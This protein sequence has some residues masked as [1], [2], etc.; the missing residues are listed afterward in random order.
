MPAITAGAD[1]TALILS[2]NVIVGRPEGAVSPEG[3]GITDC[4]TASRAGKKASQG[5]FVILSIGLVSWFWLSD[6][7]SGSECFGLENN[8]IG[9]NNSADL[10]T[11]YQ[12]SI[13]KHEACNNQ[14][15]NKLTPPYLFL[16]F[17]GHSYYVSL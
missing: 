2:L 5:S 13:L 14:M 7:S 4:D 16:F 10:V 1:N 8:D 17:V 6:F 15:Y 3:E 12:I 11:G 9:T